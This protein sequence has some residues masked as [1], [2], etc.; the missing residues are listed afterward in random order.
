M[1][2]ARLIK[3]NQILENTFYIKLGKVDERIPILQ[4]TRSRKKKQKNKIGVE[5]HG[6]KLG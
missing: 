5:R 1:A 4:L 2:W 3:V 6:F